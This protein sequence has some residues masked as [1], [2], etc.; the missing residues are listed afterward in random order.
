[1]AGLTK[2]QSFMLYA[3]GACGEELDR[4]LRSRHVGLAMT[5]AEFIRLVQRAHI[6]KQQDRVLYSHLQTLEAQKYV[7]YD[8]RSLVLTKKG[9]KVFEKA[10][11]EFGPY[12]ELARIL[13]TEDLL[14]AIPGKQTRLVE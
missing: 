9:M 5:K 11:K 2:V 8:E 3:L 14:R 1:M 13:S 12:V 10:Q 7:A 4:S 6:V